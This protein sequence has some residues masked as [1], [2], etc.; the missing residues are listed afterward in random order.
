MAKFIAYYRVSTTKQD[1]SGLALDAQ[2]LAVQSYVEQVDGDLVASFQEVEWGGRQERPELL[3]AF[4]HCRV[5]RA[6][7][8]VAKLDRLARNVRFIS[9]L[10]ESGVDFIAADLPQANRLTMHIIAA[11]AEWEREVLSQRTSKA[12]KAA[13]ARGIK[14]G[15]PNAK[16]LQPAATARSV[17]KLNKFARRMIPVFQQ[18]DPKKELSALRLATILTAAGVRS[19]RGKR[20]SASTVISMRKR[21]DILKR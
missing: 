9:E 3:K 13:K 21:I 4:G 15:N 14:V 5:S 16:A 2:K 1:K 6:I 8:V 19:Y 7:L 17:E 20:W 12:M 10:M 18:H 11:R